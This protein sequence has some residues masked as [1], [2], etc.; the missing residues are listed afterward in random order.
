MKL[1]FLLL[2]GGFASLALAAFL[3]YR[4]IEPQLPDIEV[5]RDARYQTPMS[6]YSKDGLLIAQYGEKK[7]S[8][9]SFSDVPSKVTQAFLAA[10]DNRFFDHPGVDY[11]GLLRATFSFLR[12]GEKKQGGSTITMQVARNFFLSSEKTFFRKL[13]EIVLAVKIESGLRKEQILEL[14]LN[15]IYFGHHA[16]GVMA[17]AQVYYGKGMHELE[18]DEIAMIAGLPKAPSAFNPITNPE[19]ALSRRNYV[20]RRMRKL[21]YI[22][23][24]RYQEAINRPVTAKLHTSPSELNAPYIAELIRN[25]MYQQYGEAAYTNGYKVYTTVDSR[26]QLAADRSLRLTL[27]DYD[28]R[29][30]FR[31]IKQRMD[32]NKAKYA[33]D[34]DER[35]SSIPKA[36]ETVPGLVLAVRDTSAEIYLGDKQRIVLDWDG[37]QWARKYITENGQGPTPRSAKEIL[38]TGDLIRLRKDGNDRWKLSQIPEAEGAL[39]ALDPTSG[40]VVALAGGYDFTLSNFN[41]ATQA[42]RQPGSGFKPILYAAALTEGYTPASVVNDAPIVYSDPSQEGGLWRPQNYSGRFY[43]PTRLRVALAKSRNLVSIRLLQSIGLKKAIAMATRFGFQPEELPRSLPLALGSGTA[44]PIRMAQAYAVFAN[45]G[46]RVDPYF[47]ER[48]ETEADSTIFR[49]T[50]QTA[51]ANCAGSDDHQTNFAPRILSPQVHYMMNSML[52]DV[53]RTGTATRAMELGHSDVAG[54][55]GTTNEHKDAW[56]NGYV[57]SLAAIAWVGFDSS[58]SLGEGETGGKAA[59]PMWMYFMQEALKDVPEQTFPLPSGLTTARVDP[60][61]GML[62]PPG[63]TNAIFEVFPSERAPRYYAAPR[64]SEPI[65]SEA[66]EDETRPELPEPP[67][68]RSTAEKPIESLF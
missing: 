18:L 21:G 30:G 52:Q 32:L 59:L 31:G 9:V 66:I 60:D 68:R 4:F 53:V 46:F 42:Q 10:E 61:T 39:V 15:K 49:A 36:G 50:P 41:R 1:I 38:K 67:P 65:P 23:D 2:L 24:Q 47:I 25:E 43:G 58:K 62:A 12:T 28:E 5:L 20:L 54:K 33:K 11:Q 37:L 48:I 16:Y 44:T 27:H 45:G 6:I 14:Y 55:T 7:R 13:K 8:P 26:L 56:F 29:H 35:L 3:L 64:S 57:P 63:S 19:R 17:A 40:A 51:C 34:W 22:D